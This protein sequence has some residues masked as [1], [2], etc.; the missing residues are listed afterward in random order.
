[1]VIADDANPV[2]G[3]PHPERESTLHRASYLRGRLNLLQPGAV[4]RVAA[5]AVA[6]TL[7]VVAAATGAWWF[8]SGWRI[9]RIELFTDDGPI[10][11]AGA[12]RVIG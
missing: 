5:T 2:M 11:C 8:Y 6:G 12:W 9:G 10:R 1:M 7:A 3:I 4:I